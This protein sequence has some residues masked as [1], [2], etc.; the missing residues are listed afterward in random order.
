[1]GKKS[2]TL[3]GKNGWEHQPFYHR[4]NG[5]DNLSFNGNKNQENLPLNGEN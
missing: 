1:M 5:W 3:N 4:E 2:R